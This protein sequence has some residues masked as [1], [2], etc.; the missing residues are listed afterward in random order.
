MFM[1]D[2]AV[3]RDIDPAVQL[4]DDVYLFTIDDLQQ[5]VD[6]NMQQRHTAAAAASTE[7]EHSVNVF[8]RWLYGI[9]AARSLKRIRELSHEHASDLVEKA[10]KR[11]QA[12]QDAKQILTQL[13]DT[14]TNRI[15][16]GPTQRLREAAEEQ[17]YEIVKAA[18]WIFRNKESSEEE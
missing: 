12:G 13:A 3:P 2:I 7:V 8:M 15:L 9:R 10:L 6:E 1:V 14:L 11:L 16:H 4:L 17:Q 18:D 5:V